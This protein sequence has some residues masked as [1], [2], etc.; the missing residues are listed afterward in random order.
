MAAILLDLS[1]IT[2]RSTFL[3]TTPYPYYEQLREAFEL[4]YLTGARV[5][6]VLEIDR[7]ELNTGTTY[8]LYP[9]KGNN[10]RVVDLGSGFTAFK[11]AI[12]AQ[13]APFLG[14]T[15]SQLTGIFN[16]IRTWERFTSSGH[17]VCFYIFRYRYV[18]QL[19]AD[20]LTPTQIAS[21]MGYTSTSTINSYLSAEIYQHDYEPPP[22]GTFLHK[23]HIKKIVE[24]SITQLSSAELVTLFE[25]LVSADSDNCVAYNS[26]IQVLDSGTQLKLFSQAFEFQD[27]YTGWV[28][29]YNSIDEY[30]NLIPIL[31]TGSD[32]YLQGYY[33]SQGVW[34]TGD[35]SI[36]EHV[37][38]YNAVETVTI[39]GQTWMLKNLDI[40]DGA[41][42]IYAYDNDEANVP[43][44]GRLYT[45]AAAARVAAAFSGFHLPSYDEFNTLVLY[46]N[47]GNLAGGRM[48][49]IGFSHWNSPNT[50][51]SNSSGFTA[52][53]TGYAEASLRSR[54]LLVTSIFRTS[55]VST[56]GSHYYFYLRYNLGSCSSSAIPDGYYCTVR[57]I[58]D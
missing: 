51:A 52:L 6:E 22:V 30:G 4:L 1:Q 21:T 58:A 57:L 32:W 23:S 46:L 10:V 16:K 15:L 39:G 48:K 25:G 27:S 33:F 12:A 53:G 49:E 36:S 11:A 40:D 50:S 45:A 19:A 55:S 37:A 38:Y 34:N 17:K 54:Y 26:F 13:T 9:Q 43:I 14:L 29:F 42:G 3:T 7:W 24:T 8:Y 41:G 2:D 28:L 47:A 31:N 18:K 56:A 44:Y 20:G 35:P 5:Q